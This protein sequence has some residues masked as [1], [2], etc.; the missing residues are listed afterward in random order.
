MG[1]VPEGEQI[2]PGP[3][4]IA[5][6]ILDV[7]TGPVESHIQEAAEIL[8]RGGLVAFPTETV[9]GLGADA[10]D[11][12]AVVK[13]FKAKGR[14]ADNPLIVHIYDMRQLND[15][16]RSVP[17]HARLLAEAFWPGPLTLVV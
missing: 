10:F 4:M 6:R 9:Y 8:R 7:T 5:T 14:P 15:I 17:Y 16:A 13:V 3:R 12:E 11:E 2:H 1:E